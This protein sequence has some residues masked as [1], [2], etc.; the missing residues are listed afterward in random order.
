MPVL[1][2]PFL[3]QPMLV[4]VEH[5]HGTSPHKLKQGGAQPGH[6]VCSP[7]GKKR[8]PPS[9]MCTC[10]VLRLHKGIRVHAAQK[11]TIG[12]AYLV[13]SG[14]LSPDGEGFWAVDQDHNAAQG[15]GR[16]MSLAVDMMRAALEVGAWLR[17][18]FHFLKPAGPC[19][20]STRSTRETLKCAAHQA[21]TWQR[22]QLRSCNHKYR[23]LK[24]YN[25]KWEDEEI[26]H[27]RV[28]EGMGATWAGHAALAYRIGVR[29]DL[30]VAT[31]KN[32]RLTPW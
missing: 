7:K 10:T 21:G 3:Q 11:N 14:I 12:D 26:I 8:P 5:S 15:A 4:Q 20:R 22:Q 6:D 25:I 1:F 16:M 30:L 27:A 32:A 31:Q 17:L 2:G 28:V 24:R 9:S 18:R 29:R 23:N 19:S 13:A